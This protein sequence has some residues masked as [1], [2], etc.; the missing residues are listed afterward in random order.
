MHQRIAHALLGSAMMAA[1]A[2]TALAAGGMEILEG[3]C[4]A[5][6][7]VVGP[8]P[9]TLAQLQARKGPDLFYAGNKYRKEWLEAWL[10]DPH[11]IRPAGMFFADHVKSTPSGDIVD[12]ASLAEHP[13]LKAADAVA[14]AEALMTL[15]A[16]DD[17]V[18]PGEYEEGTISLSMGEM[19]FDKFRG[20][21]ACHEIEPEYG[22]L[23]GPEMYT[24]ARRLQPDWMISYMRNP[25]AWDPRSFMPNRHLTDADLQK[26]VHYLRALAE[27]ME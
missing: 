8:A 20:C 22:G 6:H 17:L 24:A 4:A 9:E 16:G 23:S 14:V 21:L 1:T 27:E 19:M 13:A 15:R 11:R 3:D 25:Q 18:T 12:A 26:L 2:A 10:Q 7:D 5:C